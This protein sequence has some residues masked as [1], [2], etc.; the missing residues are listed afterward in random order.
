MG[1]QSNWANIRG[2]DDLGFSQDNDCLWKLWAAYPMT[3]PQDARINKGASYVEYEVQ[4]NRLNAYLFPD[5]GLKSLTCVTK[6]DVLQ[7]LEYTGYIQ[8]I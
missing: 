4:M 1:N 3:Q 8:D 5:T 7:E 2:E 6:L